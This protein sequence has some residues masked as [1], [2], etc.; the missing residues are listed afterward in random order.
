MKYES[1][2]PASP[3]TPAM[4][5]A[6]TTILAEQPTEKLLAADGADRLRSLIVASAARL[7]ML[8]GLPTDAAA[9]L[10]LTRVS[11][12]L[13]D[14]QLEL[15]RQLQPRIRR[16]DIARCLGIQPT[17]L[18]AWIRAREK[19]EQQENA[20][21][22]GWAAAV[23]QARADFGPWLTEPDDAHDDATVDGEADA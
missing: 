21:S 8:Y 12:W 17:N 10:L 15:V 6:A 4:I 5:R 18:P 16:A 23:E 2:K 14:G 3:T 1:E 11:A 19:K 20:V 13:T 9:L 22:E 7:S